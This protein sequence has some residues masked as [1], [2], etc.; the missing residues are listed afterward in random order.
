MVAVVGAEHRVVR[1]DRDAVGAVGEV[2]LAPRP[3]EVA[4]AVV[5]E[6]GM[7]A[8]ADQED[9]ILQVDGHPGHVAMRKPLRQLLP[10]LDHLVTQPTH[11]RHCRSSSARFARVK[12]C[13][14]PPDESR[15]GSDLHFLTFRVA[16]GLNAKC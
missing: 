4:L 10:A 5:A 1:A 11:R 12:L 7:I 9:P 3:E 13:E 8:P 6:D 16:A 2:A 14:Q 15:L